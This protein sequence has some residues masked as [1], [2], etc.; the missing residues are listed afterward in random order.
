MPTA[1]AYASTGII[2]DRIFVLGGENERGPLASHEVY[3]PSLEEGDPWSRR[4]PLPQPRSRFGTAVALS[5]IMLFGGEPAAAP[6]RYNASTDN[7]DMLES[8]PAP[9]GAQ[10]GVA[11]LDGVVYSLGG[12]ESGPAYAVQ[13]Q[14]YQAVYTQFLP[15]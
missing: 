8:P 13:V 14:G 1:R 2:E 5:S 12:A 6:I 9:I 4:A 3:T 15:Q 7:W 10:P 11:L